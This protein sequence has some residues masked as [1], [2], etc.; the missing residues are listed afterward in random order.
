LSGTQEEG[1]EQARAEGELA[2]EAGEGG[3]GP[4][5]EGGAGPRPDTILAPP[6]DPLAVDPDWQTVAGPANALTVTRSF[7]G[8]S[9]AQSFPI[10]NWAT[11]ASGAVG[12]NH[13]V[14]TV[15]F[16]Y[17]V[18]DKTGNPLLPSPARTWTFWSGF[19]G[20]GGACGT[21]F[22]WSDVVVLYDRLADRW[23]VSR[24]AQDQSTTFWYQCFAISQTPDPTGAYYRYA[25][26]ISRAEFNDYPKFGIWPDAYYMT[27]NRDKIFAAK[28]I[29]VVA[30]ERAKMLA[31]LSTAQMVMFT[32]NNGGN[33]AGMLPADWDGSTQPPAGA[34]NY[35]IRP[36][37]PNLGWPA[38][39]GL[40]LW[41]F[42]VDWT[43]TSNST[44]IQTTT[45]APGAFDTRLCNLNQNC[46]PQPGTAQGLDPLAYGYLMYRLVYR[47]FGDHETMLL[48]QTVDVGD[49]ANHAGIRWYELRKVI[50]AGWSIY[51][52][53]TY[54][55]D[56]SHR[57]VGSLAMDR[58]GNMALG[59]STSSSSV[60]PSIRY[61]GRQAGDPLNRL[62][63]EATLVAG[64]GS[65]TGY[66][67]WADWTQMTVDPV[68]DC[69]FWYVNAYYPT[70]SASQAWN[71]RI[72]A[73][74]FPA[75]GRG[76]A[77]PTP[78]RV[79]P[80]ATPTPPPTGASPTATPRPSCAPRPPV[81]V[82]VA[83]NGQHRLLATITANT[84]PGAPTNAL[85]SLQFGAATNAVINV[86]GGPTNQTGSFTY[87]PPAN[88]AQ[89][90]F[91]VQQATGGGYTT[92]PLVVTDGCGAW[93]TFVGG[94]PNAFQ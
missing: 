34:P 35:L 81:A 6:R 94:G 13:Y 74:S 42:H 28:G 70:T 54:A 24:F 92:V 87:T 57:W 19:S 77:T 69:T 9:T 90:T 36:L 14:Q 78:T 83:P 40:E 41:Q 45:L 85:F 73:L 56:A 62:S 20:A 67:F 76:T 10:G 47:N 80:T 48:N 60:F 51:Q 39:G 32:L 55:P 49:V 1:A 30:F 5:A 89:V 82:T 91:T 84:G 11:D 18:Y 38:P 33:R 68:D 43:T 22:I 37:D 59:Y 27:A 31:G 17:Q 12:P 63:Q 46:I 58:D 44:L 53:S 4:V 75:C 61:A 50:G 86:T 7:E 66:D 72:A 29:F 2:R 79:G 25:F 65:Q 93:P 52:Q 23:F 26:L 8:I 71:T 15:N 16:A 21:K 88:T 3:G 64:S